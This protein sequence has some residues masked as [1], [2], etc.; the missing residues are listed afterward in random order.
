MDNNQIEKRGSGYSLPVSDYEKLA[1]TVQEQGCYRRTY[2]HFLGIT[3]VT[4]IGIVLTFIGLTLT[5]NLFIQIINAV[6]FGFFSVQLGLIGHDLSHGGVFVS[7]KLNRNLALL[8]WGLGCGLSE[9][10]WF[11]KHNTHHQSP[12]HI[13]HDPDLE[14]PFVFNHE[15]AKRY[16]AFSQ[17]WVYPHQHVLF[18]FGL[19]F[20]YPYNILNSMRFLFSNFSLR[21]LT[22]ILL[23]ALHFL[24]VFG[25]TIFFLPII[26]AIVFNLVV[27]LVMGIYMGLIFA[28]NHK[29]QDM[30]EEEATYNWVQQI[31]LTRNIKPS[32]ISSYFLGGLEH[33]IEHHLFPT[34]PRFQYGKARKIVQVFCHQRKIPYHETTWTQSMGQIHSSLLEESR[35]WQT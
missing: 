10:R 9:G 14:I 22:E 17:N 5:D 4:L 13:G 1:K 30:L 34:M 12:N 26:T 24:V 6:M 3:L 35:A 31:T 16:T 19:W 29:G 8:V 28:P 18:W 7:R 23:M 21:S 33:Q 2:I 11:Y 20:V 27:F 25:L 15:Q 32:F